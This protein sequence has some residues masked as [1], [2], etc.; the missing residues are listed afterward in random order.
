MTHP[1]TGYQVIEAVVARLDPDELPYLPEAWSLYAANP[2]RLNRRREQMLGGGIIPQLAEW[3]PLVAT[4]VG[5][6]LA[7]AMKDEI[8]DGAR[9]GARLLFGRIGRRARAR[10]DA[11]ALA[12]DPLPPLSVERCQWLAGKAYSDARAAGV[13]ETRAR[14][15]MQTVLSVLLETDTGHGPDGGPQKDG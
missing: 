15:L 8:G 7:D 5:G 2:T 10:R 13:P 1:R 9:T 3:A 14:L 11:Q 6:A 12:T 4:F